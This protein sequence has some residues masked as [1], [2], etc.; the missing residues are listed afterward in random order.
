MRGLTRQQGL[1]FAGAGAACL[2]VLLAFRGTFAEMVRQWIDS[3]TY[4]HGLLILPVCVWL[5]WRQRAAIAAAPLAPSLSLLPALVALA[6]LWTASELARFALG[7]QLAAT[8]MLALAPVVVLGRDA[9]RPIAFALFFLLFAVPMGE[10][11]VPALMRYTADFAVLAL[12]VT[13]I[14]VFRDGMIISLPGADFEVV[15]ACSGIRYLL[16]AVV[17]STLFSYFTFASRRRRV[18][19]VAASFIVAIVANG[20]RAYVV[21][22]VAHLSG[23]RFGIGVDHLIFG[24]VWFGIVMLALMAAGNRF[25]DRDTPRDAAP[26]SPRREPSPPA[27]VAA[28]GVVLAVAVAGALPDLVRANA[29]SK[30]ASTPAL[31]RAAGEWRGPAAAGDDWTIAFRGPDFLEHARYER[32]AESVD[33]AIASYARAHVDGE[34]ADFENRVYRQETWQLVGENYVELAPEG[35][36]PVT[37]VQSEIR[38][39][40]RRRLV[41]HWYVVDG[42]ATASR[43]RAKFM[44]AADLMTGEESAGAVVALSAEVGVQRDAAE[45]VLRDFA[46]RHFGALN[47]SLAGAP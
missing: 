34:L 9:T 2:L 46:T 3:P 25:S 31:P 47:A 4:Q 30:A 17:A 7:A 22:L 38:G 6:F 43:V 21:M 27:W 18:A 8:A 11:L 44:A 40:A 16:T 36:S 35:A 37:L 32:G 1:A 39:G 10:E 41:W 45:A 15:K 14:P 12:V 5:I 33:V 23:Y 28:A 42:G 20:L 29:R 13:G 24:W 26:P 19:F